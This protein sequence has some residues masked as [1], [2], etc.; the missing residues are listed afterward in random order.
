MPEHLDMAPA[1][2]RYRGV[3][4]EPELARVR[5]QDGPGAPVAGLEPV[6][7]LRLGVGD[8]FHRT[9]EAEMHGRHG[10]DDGDVRTD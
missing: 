7:Y 6:E 2:G 8:L 4:P 10:G 9:K 5:R 3:M 1:A